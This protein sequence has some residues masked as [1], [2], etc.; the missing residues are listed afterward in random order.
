MGTFRFLLASLVMLSHFP[1]VYLKSNLGQ[2]SVLA[3][4]FISGWL[5]AMS[6]ERFV[7]KSASPNTAFFLDRFIKIWPSYALV[8]VVS[9]CFFVVQGYSSSIGAGCRWNC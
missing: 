2:S 8:F 5:M 3:F 6:Y 4:Y 7:A 1:G 9:L